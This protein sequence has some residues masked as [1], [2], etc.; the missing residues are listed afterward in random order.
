MSQ[1]VT[2]PVCKS[3]LQRITKD[4]LSRKKHLDALQKAGIKISNDP[5]LKLIKSPQK[6][7]NKNTDIEQ[8]VY[9]LSSLENVV[10]Q[11]QIQQ[12]QILNYLNIKSDNNKKKKV[13][14]ISQEEILDAIDKCVQIYQRKSRWVKIDDVISL[15]KIYHEE[16]LKN[17]N[18]ILI[19]MFNQNMI[20]LAEGGD[21]KYPILYQN[22]I[23]GMV[24]HQ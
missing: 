8:I 18:N 24:A 12:E 13:R 23:Y 9:K 17:F 3:Q 2:C 21:P 15:L 22:R 20:D 1:K 5:A 11:L 6:K 7:A 4:H 19:K 16:D 10:N 14:K